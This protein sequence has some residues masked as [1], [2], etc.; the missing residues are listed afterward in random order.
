MQ[1]EG[2][3][4]KF[5]S[6]FS[7]KAYR[8][9]YR[10]ETPFWRKASWIAQGTV[11][12]LW[13]AWRGHAA[14][15]GVYLYREAC[16]IGTAFPERLWAARLPLLL[17]FDDAI[18]LP[19]ASEA[20]R[21]FAW[22]KNPQK[23]HTLLRLAKVVTVCNDFLA[24]YARQYASDVRII[25]T[26]IDTDLYRPR[27]KPPSDTVVVGWSGS[28]TTL[29]HFRLVEPALAIL[30]KR[31]GAR[32]RFRLLGVP[33]YQNPSLGI[34]SLPW[35]PETEVDDLTEID[36]GLMP[37][38]D[39]PWSRGKCALKAL[40]YMAL[41]IPPV[42]SPVGMNRQVVQE[43]VNGLWASTLDEWVEKVSWLI[44]RPEERQRL[45]AAARHTVQAAYSVHANA[46][47]YLA[48]FQA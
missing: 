35:R 39:E 16:L 25:P 40:Q 30:R 2:Y 22:L 27:P 46:P 42:V 20:H 44:E 26:T 6:F 4:L 17:D 37:L 45:G 9:F 14:Y 21:A 47:K 1:E 36:I 12:Q 34:E 24:A 38:P 48:A 43:G 33:H 5:I 13:Q 8:A 15:R 32:V 3:Q 41:G 11:R 23:L 28:L 31:Y 18:W 10:K 29:A 19:A 7:Q